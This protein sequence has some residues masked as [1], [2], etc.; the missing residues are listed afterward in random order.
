MIHSSIGAGT[1]VDRQLRFKA[2]IFFMFC[3]SQLTISPCSLALSRQKEKQWDLIQPNF[4]SKHNSCP[5]EPYQT[6]MS[7]CEVPEGCCYPI[8]NKHLFLTLNSL[9]TVLTWK[10]LGHYFFLFCAQIQEPL[11]C[12]HKISL[13]VAWQRNRRKR[14]FNIIPG[15]LL[16]IKRYF[17]VLFFFS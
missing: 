8:K 17:M 16:E 3:L 9:I 13:A 7:L 14:V 10:F 12:R 6:K 15:T 1:P 4:N 2:N 5:E 11:K